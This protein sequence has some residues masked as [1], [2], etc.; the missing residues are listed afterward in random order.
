MNIFKKKVPSAELAQV[1]LDEFVENATMNVQ[2]RR[3][4]LIPDEKEAHFEAKM[5]L[6]RLALVLIAVMNEEQKNPNFLKVKESLEALVFPETQE[7]VRLLLLEL[8]SAMKHLSELLFP[9]DKAKWMS[10]SR[11]WLQDINIQETNPIT[12]H[13]FAL[14]WMEH[15]IATA[16]AI[17]ELNPT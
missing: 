15:Y 14:W 17:R 11:T 7:E 8:R 16:K 4:L 9:P 3:G 5:R 13:L 12:L 6:Y 2:P 10:W 1:V